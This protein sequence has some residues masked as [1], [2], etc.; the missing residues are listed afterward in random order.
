MGAGKVPLERRNFRGQPAP[1]RACTVLAPG[2]WGNTPRAINTG[3][4][5]SALGRGPA[6]GDVKAPRWL[7][8]KHARLPP[9][10]TGFNTRPGDGLSQVGIMQDDGGFS[11]GSP[12]SPAP[13]FR[14]RSIFTSITLI[15]SQDP[16]VKSHPNIFTSLNAIVKNYRVMGR[17]K[18]VCRRQ[19]C[20]SFAKD[21][22]D[23]ERRKSHLERHLSACTGAKLF[24][25]RENRVTG[26]SRWET[27]GGRG[28][29]RETSIYLD[30]S[31]PGTPTQQ[32]P[33]G[34]FLSSALACIMV[35]C[36]RETFHFHLTTVRSACLRD[37]SFSKKLQRRPV[38]PTKANRVQ[39]PAG[40]LL[41][42]CMWGIVPDDAAGQRVFSGISLASHLNHP[43][44]FS[45][46]YC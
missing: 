11:R 17:I 30:V 26:P 1:G 4:P 8:D 42:F 16:A 34:L 14:R 25:R 21:P 41:D 36:G 39:Y 10:R 7:S 43:H 13:S 23:V 37:E 31:R 32:K 44:R 5:A 27:R 24:G 20:L 12:V 18:V 15:G 33:S 3:G 38:S 35:F 46:P 28:L 22:G 9:R 2:R 45:R 19:P 6:R 29:C 40:S